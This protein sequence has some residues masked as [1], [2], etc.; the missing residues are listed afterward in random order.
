MQAWPTWPL[1]FPPWKGW[2]QIVKEFEQAHLH[3][4]DFETCYSNGG[5]WTSSVSITW[6]PVRNA[7]G[8]PH[9]R[10]TESESVLTSSPADLCV[11]PFE[12]LWPGWQVSKLRFDPRPTC[13]Q[14]P[15]SS[16]EI[17]G[18]EK[19]WVSFV[20]IWMSSEVEGKEA[21]RSCGGGPQSSQD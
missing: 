20:K 1:A 9:P 3:P 19:I 18:N 5:L 2:A 7:A 14:S 21:E 13:F 6:E 16:S 11:Q 10:P 8:R 4:W 17:Q 15:H 12:K